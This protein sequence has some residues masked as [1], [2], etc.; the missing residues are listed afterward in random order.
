MGILHHVHTMSHSLVL[1]LR[2][3]ETFGCGAPFSLTVKTSSWFTQIL[4]QRPHSGKPVSVCAIQEQEMPDEVNIDELLDLKTD[5]ERTH[6]LK[7]TEI[8]CFIITHVTRLFY[9]YH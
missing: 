8:S 9:Y 7:V 2:C 5:E 4:D 6:R 1:S 3:T